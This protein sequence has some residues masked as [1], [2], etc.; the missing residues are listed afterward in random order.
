MNARAQGRSRS[1]LS[2]VWGQGAIG[3]GGLPPLNFPRMFH[4]QR[5]SSY[6][7]FATLLAGC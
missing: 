2:N 5:L 3:S 7:P 4:P 6:P 1:L